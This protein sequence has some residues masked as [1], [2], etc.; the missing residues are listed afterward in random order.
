VLVREVEVDPA[1]SADLAMEAVNQNEESVAAAPAEPSVVLTVKP[2]V[3]TAKSAPK[4]ATAGPIVAKPWC[5][6]TVTVEYIELVP[7][8]GAVADA[9]AEPAKPTT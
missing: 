1:T 4:A 3:S 9:A 6:F 7:S 5:K 2:A 8:P